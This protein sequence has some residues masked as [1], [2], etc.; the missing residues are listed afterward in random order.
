M[1]ANNIIKLF[2]KTKVFLIGDIML[3]RYVFGRV[4]RISPEA[5]VPIFLKE[6]FREVLGGSG[7]VLNNLAS[8]GTK[9]SYLS[10]IGNDENGKKIKRILKSLNIS[11]Y[12]LT[13][14]KSR[15]TTIK[16]RYIS[17]S[18]QIIRVDEELT[19]NI[20]RKIENELIKKI[21][22]LLKNKD[23][24]V[25]SDY[26]KGLITKKLCEYIINKGNLLKIPIIID[27]KNENFNI[28]KNA[29]LITPNQLEA[30]KI[31]QM[32][33]V[34]DKETER[35]GKTIMK[36]YNIK[37]VLVTRGEKG[38]SLISRKES[39]HSPTISKAVYDVSGAGDTVLAVIASCI[40]NNIDK[41]KTLTLANKAAGKVIGKV[42]TSSITLQELFNNEITS[43]SN[44]IFDIKLL[45]EKL[46][47]DREKGLKIGFTN[48]CF[49]VLHY[50]HLSYIERS[51]Q[52][53]DK[54]IIALNSDSSVKKIKGKN[55]PINN[56]LY[57]A[58][59][60]SSLEFCDYVIIFN[61]KTPLSII[62]K[63]KPDLITKGGDY[64][65]KKIVGEDEVKK[66]GGIVIS[67]DFIKGLSSTKVIDKLNK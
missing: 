59:I 34:S 23:V 11:N 50:G 44:K 66:W 9:T 26:N 3:D 33:V 8:L 10:I 52:H 35:C 30:S 12:I 14:D 39:L 19:D 13:T 62:K 17:N 21:D 31:S 36:K 47:R 49:D 7:N 18:Q 55:R 27:P 41:I 63:I 51:R 54:L 2:K 6:S 65:N 61:E 16:T 28:Y 5:P 56:Q 25:I 15:K 20:S 58:K 57:R 29:T 46:K 38:L 1:L 43:S 37:N 48:G 40:P 4:S 67:L 53:C 42:G 60:L 64:K 32:H 45:C 24:I 22:K